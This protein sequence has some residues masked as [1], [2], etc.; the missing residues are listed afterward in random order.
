ME[1]LLINWICLGALLIII[2]TDILLRRNHKKQI[3]LWRAKTIE[4]LKAIQAI[5]KIVFD[6]QNML[7][8]TLYKRM[9]ELK[10]RVDKI[11]AELVQVKRKTKTRVKK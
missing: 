6:E 2:L 8:R 10:A 1:L 5:E 4:A 7:A 11:E 3:T 9:D